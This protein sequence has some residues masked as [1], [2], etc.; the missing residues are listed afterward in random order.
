M[1]PAAARPAMKATTIPATRSGR[2]VR[3]Q[4][5]AVKS[6]NAAVSADVN[7]SLQMNATATPTRSQQTG[8]RSAKVTSFGRKIFPGAKI[9]P[10]RMRKIAGNHHAKCMSRICQRGKPGAASEEVAK[11]KR[12]PGKWL[13]IHTNHGPTITT[14]RKRFLQCSKG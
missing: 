8:K 10:G 3:S 13:S 12:K 1:M 7:S 5:Q 2:D 9:K 11:R 4:A 6:A 14:K